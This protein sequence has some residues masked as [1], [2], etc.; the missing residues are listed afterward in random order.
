MILEGDLTQGMP[1]SVH[2]HALVQLRLP[3]PRSGRA[4]EVQRDSD[5]DQRYGEQRAHEDGGPRTM[6]LVGI[7]AVGQDR[8]L[9]R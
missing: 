4:E 3:A 9:S 8:R 1:R 5:D 7:E 2:P 6:D